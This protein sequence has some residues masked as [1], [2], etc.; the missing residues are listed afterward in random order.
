MP[1]KRTNAIK[2]TSGGGCGCSQS[3]NAPTGFVA[4]GS[5][6]YNS[7]V[8]QLTPGALDVIE[9]K[10][11]GG[12]LGIPG[13]GGRTATPASRALPSS[14]GAKRKPAAAKPK[15]KPAA[16]K[17]KPKSKAKAKPKSKKK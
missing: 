16:T 5:D 14:G 3:Q 4:G 7:V 1:P 12:I 10:T 11:G 13:L 6:S 8:S 9:G 15:R 17:P 2:R